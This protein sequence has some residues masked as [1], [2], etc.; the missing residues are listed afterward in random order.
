MKFW[1]ARHA[2]VLLPA[3]ICYGVT[4]VAADAALTA[5]SAKMLAALLPVGVVVYASPLR[6]CVQLAEQLQA[7]RPDLAFCT[8]TRLQE[9]NFGEWEGRP[10]ASVPRAAFD[11]WTEDFPQHRFGGVECVND[12][13]R[14]VGAAWDAHQASLDQAGGIAWIT[15]AGVARALQ[16][17]LGGKRVAGTMADWPQQ[18]PAPG[19]CFSL[20][21]DRLHSTVA[22]NAIAPE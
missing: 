13:L 9:M 6:R 2:P 8:D 19:A 4:D 17:L 18:A 21:G 7:L 3:G 20:E 16:W 15:H 14:R 22:L 1:L 5:R 12:V 10:W 11:A